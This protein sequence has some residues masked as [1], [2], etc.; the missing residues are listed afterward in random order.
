M[1]QPVASLEGQTKDYHIANQYQATCLTTIVIC[2]AHS[3]FGINLSLFRKYKMSHNHKMKQTIRHPNQILLDYNKTQL[4]FMS[5]P[6]RQVTVA[7]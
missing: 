1:A 2:S 4:I 5:C 6:P 3:K 7:I